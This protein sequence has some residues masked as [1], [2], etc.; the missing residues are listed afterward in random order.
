VHT[1]QQKLT[2]SSQPKILLQFQLLARDQWDAIHKLKK[3]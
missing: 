3:Y 2:T 1:S